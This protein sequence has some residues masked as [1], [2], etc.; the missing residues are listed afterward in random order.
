MPEPPFKDPSELI[1]IFTTM[2]EQNLEKILMMQ[3]SEHM[4]DE[5][6]ANFHEATTRQNAE[7]DALE[8][9]EQW[10]N[11]TIRV[12]KSELSALSQ[13]FEEVGKSSL[14]DPT[15]KQ[16]ITQITRELYVECVKQGV[17]WKLK[18]SLQDDPDYKKA[19][20]MEGLQLLA[21]CEFV[22]DKTIH[23]LK[24]YQKKDPETFDKAKH[25]RKGQQRKEQDKKRE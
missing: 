22:I 24:N 5:V 8:E 10:N 7:I 3:D 17:N 15:E 2:E 19:M 14:I 9:A 21:E 23:R 12:I 1:E 18:G 11:E 20:Q 16:K 13:A 6:K 25:Y 4:L